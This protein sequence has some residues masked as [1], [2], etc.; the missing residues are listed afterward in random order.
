MINGV[1]NKK[2]CNEGYKICYDGI[3]GKFAQ[4]KYLL[5]LLK[6]TSPKILAVATTDHLWGTGIVLRDTCTLDAD[7]WSS[8]GW[9]SCMLITI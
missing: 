5:S 6:T 4:N 2:L 9:L 3:K 1:Y 8:T 7:K